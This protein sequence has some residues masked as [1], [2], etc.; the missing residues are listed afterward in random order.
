[1]LT[2]FPNI[3]G[4]ILAL[5]IVLLIAIGMFSFAFGKHRKD[6]KDIDITISFHHKNNKE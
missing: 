6:S 1:M 4:F 3:L 5:I 2:D